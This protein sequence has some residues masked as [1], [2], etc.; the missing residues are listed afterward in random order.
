MRI[1]IIGAGGHAKVVADVARSAGYVVECFV[2]NDKKEHCGLRVLTFE[3]FSKS[4]FRVAALGIGD[5]IARK[6]VYGELKAKEIEFL[7]LIHA[8][9][10]ISRSVQISEAVVVMP[11]CVINADAKIEIGAIINSG[12][13]I[14][15]DCIIGEFAH[16]SPNAALAG[17]ASV[18]E[19]SHVGIGASVIQNIKIGKN[20]RI[21]AGAAVIRDVADDVTVAG[22]PAGELYV[23]K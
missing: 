21:G 1:V 18:G 4:P 8:S 5:N 14:E 3:E 22:V 9:A 17:G 13:I 20:S 6:K 15:H 19:Y 2:A 11:L 10:V 23:I 16:V 7:P 12:V